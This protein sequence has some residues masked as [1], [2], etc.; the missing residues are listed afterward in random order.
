MQNEIDRTIGKEDLPSMSDR[1]AMPYCSA[2][3]IE[4]QRRANI[5]PFLVIRRTTANVAVFD[6]AIPKD[7][8]C[9]IAL[10][11]IL[12]DSANFA[13][14]ME[15]R[16]ERFLENDGKTLKKVSKITIRDFRLKKNP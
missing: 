3:I 15:F 2:A 14:A 6:Y 1:S 4:L 12:S 7:A 13:D 10:G 8:Y 5:A 9:L 11:D 16:P